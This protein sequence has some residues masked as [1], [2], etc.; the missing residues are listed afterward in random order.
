MK[1]L[2]KLGLVSVPLWNKNREGGGET[3]N[4]VEYVRA[5]PLCLG[6]KPFGFIYEATQASNMV[7]MTSSTLVE[8]LLNADRW[9]EMFMGMIG[10]CTTMEVISDGTE[11]SRNGSLQL[12]KAEVQLISPLVLVR[13]LKFIR[14]A[15]QQAERLWIVVDLS[16]DSRMDGQINHNP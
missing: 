10:S 16:I 6:T 9:R 1:E 2:L 15:K 11:G 8:A 13:V 7:S 12:M 14:F 5:F 4:F 3:L